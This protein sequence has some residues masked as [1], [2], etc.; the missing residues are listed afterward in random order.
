MDAGNIQD[1]DA[2]EI[3]NLCMT[4]ILKSNVFLVMEGIGKETAIDLG[5][6]NENYLFGLRFGKIG[7]LLQHFISLREDNLEL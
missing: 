4:H 5:K 2:R 7:G 6:G 1:I 3:M